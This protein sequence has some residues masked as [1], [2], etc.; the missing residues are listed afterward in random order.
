LH[1]LDFPVRG[2]QAAYGA[3]FHRGRSHLEWCLV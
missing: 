3:T 2:D 1:G